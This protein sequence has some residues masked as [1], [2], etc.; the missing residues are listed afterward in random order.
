MEYSERHPIIK[1]K[2]EEFASQCKS[3][4]QY[5]RLIRR[6]GIPYQDITTASG[7]ELLVFTGS[8]G[9]DIVGCCVKRVNG[10]IVVDDM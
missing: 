3:L 10:Q 5:A 1:E 6:A 4:E 2:L 9:C 7:R 8:S